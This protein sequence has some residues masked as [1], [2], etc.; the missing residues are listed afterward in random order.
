M[1]MDIYPRWIKQIGV[2]ALPIFFITNFPPMFVLNKMTPAYYVW[3][4]LA[5]IL[6]L[7]LVRAFWS[8]GLRNYSSAS[9]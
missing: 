1:P 7:L 4:A 5:P 3:A 6:L 8:W 9:S 2:F